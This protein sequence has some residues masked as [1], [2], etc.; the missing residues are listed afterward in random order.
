MTPQE[1]LKDC[2]DSHVVDTEEGKWLIAR[3]K[4]LTEALEKVVCE[5]GDCDL[6][7]CEL[8]RKALESEE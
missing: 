2:E 3:I 7:E 4:K 6:V 8:A 1:K 5:K